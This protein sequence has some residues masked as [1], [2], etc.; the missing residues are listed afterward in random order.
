MSDHDADAFESLQAHLAG[1]EPDWD[2]D[3]EPAP[4]AAAANGRLRAL[5][6]LRREMASLNAV[7][8]A[9]LE[10]I[11]LWRRTR[12]APL[13]DR[14][15]WLE[16]SVAG[17]LKAQLPEDGSGKTVSLPAGKVKATK[18]QPTIEV[19]AETFL[20]WAR[21]H[22]P[23]LIHQAPAPP[24]RPD[25]AALRAMVRGLNLK[26]VRPGE[27]VQLVVPVDH[28]AMDLPGADPRASAGEVRTVDTPL[29]GVVVKARPAKVEVIP[30]GDLLA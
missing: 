9:E 16:A 2:A 18:Q 13:E 25:Q 1:P 17:W 19:D 20:A 12:L 15:N 7:A 14:A 22:R 4:D 21:T 24:A 28:L 6:A 23:D 3:P 10:Q 29:P 8:A 5:A 11:E 30:D 27:T 26:D